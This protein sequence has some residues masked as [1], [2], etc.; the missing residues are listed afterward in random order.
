MRVEY[1][2]LINIIPLIRKILF[3]INFQTVEFTFFVQF[4]F[5]ELIQKFLYKT[6]NNRMYEWNQ[7]TWIKP[8]EEARVVHFLFLTLSITKSDPLSF[9]S[10]SALRHDHFVSNGV[11]ER[12]EFSGSNQSKSR[13]TILRD[14]FC[15]M[16]QSMSSLEHG[17]FMSR[18]F[19][20]HNN[21]M[22]GNIS[23][24]T[25]NSNIVLAYH[26]MYILWQMTGRFCKVRK[27]ILNSGSLK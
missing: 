6:Q 7:I 18:P 8:L 16:D 3:Y 20:I 5:R 11:K 10:F 19:S 1:I 15:C 13:E 21:K 26:F 23:N 24:F 9:G 14:C 12:G 25:T 2:F 17:I 27:F 4:T 22:I